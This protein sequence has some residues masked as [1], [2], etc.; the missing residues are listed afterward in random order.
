MVQSPVCEMSCDPQVNFHVSFPFSY[1]KNLT[2]FRKTMILEVWDNENYTK[3]HL[4][5]I[6]KLSM[7]QGHK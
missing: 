6:V 2:D 5:G 3:S 1:S 4:V 7:E